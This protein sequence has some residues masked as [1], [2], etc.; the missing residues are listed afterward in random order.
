MIS[1]VNDKSKVIVFWR[2]NVTLLAALILHMQLD[3]A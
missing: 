2:D 1:I 3:I